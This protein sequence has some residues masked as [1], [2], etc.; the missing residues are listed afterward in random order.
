MVRIK[1]KSLFIL[2]FLVCLILTLSFTYTKYI[3]N[4]V[5]NYYLKTKKF[6]FSSDNLSINTT[7]NS[8]LNWDGSSIDV[9]LK[10]SLSNTQI[11]GYDIEYKISCK[12][13]GDESS[14]IDCY[15]TENDSSSYTGV[16]S[17]VEACV[18]STADGIDVSNYTKKDCELSGY[19]WYQQSTEKKLS[20]N[21]KL[22]DNTKSIKDVKV[23]LSATSIS[24]YKLELK[25]VYTIHKFDTENDSIIYKL[26]DYSDYSNLLLSNHNNQSKCIN[27]NWNSDELKIDI[28]KNNL[29]NYSVDKNNYINDVEI[30]LE[31][32]E[33]INIDFYKTDNS[34][35]YTIDDFNIVEMSKCS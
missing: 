5:W 26:N 22:N 17:G 31:S 11:T 18:N 15:F 3:H 21:L 14:Y 13:L 6:Y 30:K 35:N 32:N 27:I 33:N 34:K 23:E 28:D 25:G 10:N 7:K 12:V 24:P 9:N 1:K 2:I 20:F 29:I 19:N 16:L 8:N 4:S